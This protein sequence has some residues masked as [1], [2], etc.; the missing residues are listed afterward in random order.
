MTTS[1]DEAICIRHWDYSETSQTVGLFSQKCGL[2]RAIAKGSRRERGGF[3]GGVDLLTRAEIT[4]TMKPGTELGTLVEWSLVESFPNIRRGVRA[5]NIA[6]F[7]ADLVGRLFETHDPHP[8]MYGGFSHLLR[9]ISAGGEQ[10]DASNELLLLDF[11]WMTLKEAGLQ[12]ILGERTN[13]VEVVHFDP[14]DGG[15]VI[16]K[17]NASTWRVRS[18]TIATLDVL[19]NQTGEERPDLDPESIVRANRLLAAYIRDTLGEEPFTMRRLFGVL[20]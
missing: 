16:E 2:V 4:L 8:N 12:P 14:R 7:A 3:S 11:Q 19:R 13:G 9:H 6:Y 17:P 15:R 5:N 1:E 10:E 18:L 20:T